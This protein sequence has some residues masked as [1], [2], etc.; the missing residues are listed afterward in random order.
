MG[1]LIE[2]LKNL[3]HL[4]EVQNDLNKE[5]IMTQ[6]ILKKEILNTEETCIY[7]MISKDALYRITARGELI[8]YKPN[9]RHM[10]FKK[11]DLD[12]WLLHKK[13]NTKE[14]VLENKVN[15]FFSQKTKKI[16]Q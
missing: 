14:K 4:M 9:G 3:E 5:I 10:F 1:E 13:N 8:S 7:L 12:A 16:I 15:D 11:S 2:R 6:N